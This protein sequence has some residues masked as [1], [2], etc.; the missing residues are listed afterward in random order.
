[1]LAQVIAVVAGEDDDRVVGEFEIVEGLEDA[2]EA[3]V[4]G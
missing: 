2:T 3:I 1:V 4:G